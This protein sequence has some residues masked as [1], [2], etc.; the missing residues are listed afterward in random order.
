MTKRSEDYDDSD[1]GEDGGESRLAGGVA[2]GAK[3]IAGE[4]KRIH[5]PARRIEPAAARDA[6]GESRQEVRLRWAEGQADVG[7]AVRRA[8]PADPLSIHVRAGMEGRMSEL[9]LHLGFLRCGDPAHP[10]AGYDSGRGLAG[11]LAGD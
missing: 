1:S 2:G 7:R 9:L 5:A 11:D 6:V 3:T 8:G 4:R 10:A